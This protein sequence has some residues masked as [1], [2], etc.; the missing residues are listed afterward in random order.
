MADDPRSRLQHARAE[1]VEDAL[2]QRHRE[3]LVDRHDGH[4]V[5]AG[6]RGCRRRPR[7]VVARPLDQPVDV[8]VGDQRLDRHGHGGR[9][10]EVGV[11]VGDRRT[12]QRGKQWRLGAE[13]VI[14]PHPLDRSHDL[15]QR[16]PLRVRAHR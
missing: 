6:G 12:E 13:W 14:E 10:G 2:D 7:R 4:G 5:A 15:D 3:S 16:E 9:I 8:V 1:R 11:A